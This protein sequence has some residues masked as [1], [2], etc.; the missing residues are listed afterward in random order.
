MSNETKKS[1]NDVILLIVSPPYIF[2]LLSCFISFLAHPS[3]QG[4]SGDFLDEQ[5][6]F[7]NRFQ[8]PLCVYLSFV[9]SYPCLFFFRDNK[10]IYP[11]TKFFICGSAALALLEP[12]FNS[13]DWFFFWGVVALTGVEIYGLYWEAS[14]KVKVD[15]GE[16]P[17]TVDPKRRTGFSTASLHENVQIVGGTGT[18][19]THYVIKPFIEQTIQKGL[20]CFIYDV[21]SNMN[22][23]VAFYVSKAFRHYF[24][25][26]LVEPTKSHTYNPL[27]GNNPGA[28]ANRVYTA[29]FYETNNGETYYQKLAE[30][31]LRNLI[32]L[33]MKEIKTLTFQDLLL[34]TQEADT[35]KTINWFCTKYPDNNYALYFRDQWL[36]KAPKE[37]R[38]ELSGLVNKLQRFCSSEWSFLLNVRNPD[39][40]MEKVIAEGQILLFAPDSARYLEDAKALSILAMMDMSEQLSNRYRASNLKPFRVFLDEFYN[41]A[42][43]RFID[44]INKCREAKINLFL[45]HQ[46]LGDLRGVSEEFLEQVMNTASNKIILR[47]NDPDTAESFARQF[48]TELDKNHRVESF[49]SDGTAAGYSK[50]PVEM[51]RFHPNLIKELQAGHAII[52]EVGAEGVNVYKTALRFATQAPEH[53]NPSSNLDLIKSRS[54]KIESTL[55][56]LIK[57]VNEGPKTAKK[58]NSLGDE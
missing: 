53:F 21:K 19:K 8:F 50:A 14:K 44:F 22:R 32:G 46:S 36:G 18:G 28:I 48:G 42:Y 16:Y 23:D 45:A 26:N 51:F 34:A 5:S 3:F 47:V 11:I 39:I 31:F 33:L 58:S 9:L 41:L 10:S 56:E 4:Y 2:L 25:F 38:M 6:M 27:F 49:Q 52:K 57:P 24:H 1:L 17:L 43:P 29:L 54:G 20:G 37:R 12:F 40:Q 35:F 7:Q 55:A 15:V 13:F 30:A